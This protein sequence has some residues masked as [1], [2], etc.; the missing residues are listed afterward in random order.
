MFK[1]QVD[2]VDSQVGQNYNRTH[3]HIYNTHTYLYII[4]LSYNI[5]FSIIKSSVDRGSSTNHD[6]LW[7]LRCSEWPVIRGA[8]IDGW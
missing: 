1:N 6:E 3:S 4:N 8:V 2:E 5:Y 7:T